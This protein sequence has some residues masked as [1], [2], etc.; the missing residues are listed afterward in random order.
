MRKIRLVLNYVVVG[1]VFDFNFSKDLNLKQNLL[2]A[3]Y[4][5]LEKYNISLNKEPS[6]Y[7]SK[8]NELLDINLDVSILNLKDGDELYVF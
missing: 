5:L 1:K 8:T 3:S 2:L 7:F 6:A 4:I